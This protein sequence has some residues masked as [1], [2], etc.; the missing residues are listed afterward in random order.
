MQ[1]IRDYDLSSVNKTTLQ[2]A[3]HPDP[4]ILILSLDPIPDVACCFPRA[5][6]T[7]PPSCAQPAHQSRS[8]NGCQT[9]SDR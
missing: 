2:S 5:L 9:N 4:L 7:R 6:A 1:V 8:E 3:S